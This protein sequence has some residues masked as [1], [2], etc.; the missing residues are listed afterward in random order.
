MA[1]K[2]SRGFI[3]SQ[4]KW[5][6][7]HH[8]QA[9]HGMLEETISILLGLM[10]LCC[11]LEVEDK[12]KDS[13]IEVLKHIMSKQVGWWWQQAFSNSTSVI[14][15]W[16][17]THFMIWI[18]IST[19]QAADEQIRDD[20]TL[21]W[22]VLGRVQIQWLAGLQPKVVCILTATKDNHVMTP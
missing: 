9:A 15:T 14:Q 12:G 8:S 16:S 22:L 20:A 11:T 7:V 17:Q 6:S 5:Q 13:R 10:C 2:D 19:L 4:E 1:F 21:D 18:I 3:S